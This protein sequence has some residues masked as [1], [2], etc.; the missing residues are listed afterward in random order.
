MIEIGKFNL[1]KA[2]RFTEHGCYLI[3]DKDVEV[4]LPNKYVPEYL[5]AGEKIEVFVYLDSDERFSCDGDGV[6]SVANMVN[7]QS[8][9]VKV[10]RFIPIQFETY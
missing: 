8:I 3:D 9:R 6:I 1:L 4:L 10:I 2:N 7:L 5:K